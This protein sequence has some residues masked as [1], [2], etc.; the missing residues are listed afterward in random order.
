M[1]LYRQLWI[2]IA[3]LMMTVFSITFVIN[4]LSSSSYLE[5]QLS[6]KNSDD[7]SALAVSLSQ[8]A[9][10]SISLEIQLATLLDQGSYEQV[11]FVDADGAV[12]FNRRQRFE[13]G[14]A[15]GWIKTLFPIESVPGSAEVSNGWN[16]LGSVTLTSNDDFAY[17]ELWSSAKRTLLALVLA[18]VAAGTAASLLLRMILNP[19]AQVVDQA[20]A[21]GKR[22]FLTLPEPFTTE[23][24]QVTRA[25]NTLAERVRG[26]LE[27]E[28]QRLEKRRE[29]TEM[30]PLTGLL[31]RQ[32]FMERL[33]ARL[34]ANDVDSEGAIALVRLN[35]LARMNQVYGRKT[36]D[37]VLRDIGENLRSGEF[38]DSEI[39]IGRLNGSDFCVLA[40]RAADPIQLG[41]SLRQAVEEVLTRHELQHETSLPTSCTQY[42]DS[43]TLSEVLSD[44]DEAMLLVETDETPQVVLATRAHHRVASVREQSDHWQDAITEA[45]T[46]HRLQLEYYP[47]IDGQGS[48]LYE[49]GM[50]RIHFRDELLNAGVFMPWVHRL[51]LVGEVDRAVVCL[52]LEHIAESRLRTCVNLTAGSLTDPDFPQWV[53]QLLQEHH[54]HAGRLCLDVGESVAFSHPESFRK[55]CAHVHPLGCRVGLEHMGYRVNDIGMLSELGADYLK[56]DG[57]FIKGLDSNQGGRALLRTYVGIAQ[58]LGIDCIAEGVNN[59][60][61]YQAA[62][63]CGATGVTGRGVTPPG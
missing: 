33:A 21:I 26:M 30:D 18:I 39:A 32:S 41:E 31:L 49:E 2:A 59:A 40:P 22:R 57:L 15:P 48:L 16:L 3:V 12:V 53:E 10:D 24:A 60:A 23:L 34:D 11:E 28:S 46:E 35:N 47:V 20:E 8:Q 56:I 50:L 9:L 14:Q 52:A 38:A 25:M 62:L 54:A 37:N 7:A 51:N 6:I 4:G 1:S 27:R 17:D 55:L 63:N 5:R 61:E 44:L 58:S 13:L 29:E 45:L 19:L 36:L 43:D 42:T